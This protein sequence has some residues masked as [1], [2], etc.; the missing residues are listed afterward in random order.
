MHSLLRMK[1]KMLT[2]APITI[3]ITHLTIKMGKSTHTTPTAE[4]KH[5]IKIN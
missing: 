5:S 4:L 2:A 1:N 3:E